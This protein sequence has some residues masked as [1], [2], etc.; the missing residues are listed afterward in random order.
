MVVQSLNGCKTKNLCRRPRTCLE[1]KNGHH[2]LKKVGSFRKEVVST[3]LPPFLLS[4]NMPRTD[5]PS[6][7]GLNESPSSSSFRLPSLLKIPSSIIKASLEIL[8][9]ATR[10]K[11]RVENSFAKELLYGSCFSRKTPS[12][13]VTLL[14]LVYQLTTNF[15]STYMA[16]TLVSTITSHT[17][18]RQQHRS[19]VVIL[20]STIS[21]IP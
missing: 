16:L 6:S 5:S 14:L 15:L 8:S 13:S 3:T 21:Q 18:S 7:T 11:L 10:D 20:L 9:W 19:S 1:K 4:R 2:W 17:N 12:F